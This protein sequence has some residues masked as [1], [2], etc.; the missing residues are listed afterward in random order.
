V[1]G[2][3]KYALLARQLAASGAVQID[4]TFAQVEQVIPGGLPRSAYE[5][6]SWWT[7]NIGFTAQSRHGWTDAGYRVSRV[8]L[9]DTWS[10]SPKQPTSS[11]MVGAGTVKL[12]GM[13]RCE[14]GSGE[15]AGGG[16]GRAASAAVG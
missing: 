9:A 6:R 4:M 1:G 14:G 10:R 15:S 2:A 12:W 7:G 16:G 5:Y 8:D 11:Q 3:S 13:P